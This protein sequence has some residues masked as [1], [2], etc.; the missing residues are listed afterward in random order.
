MKVKKTKAKK[1]KTSVIIVIA[2]MFTQII[3]MS[4]L[5]IVA[6]KQ[7][8]SNVQKSAVLNV[9]TALS[10][11]AVILENYIEDAENYLNAYSQSG[12]IHDMLK[13]Q[14]NK[15][16]MDKAQAYTVR[17]GMDR[18]NLEGIYASNWDTQMLVHTNDAVR[19]KVTR[20]DEGP[21]KELHEAMLAAD[22][23]YN[24]GFIISP[25]SQQQI[26]SMYKAVVDENN[27]PIGLVGC[28]IYTTGIKQL[29]NELPTYGIESTKCYL[30]NNNSKQ[31]IFHED[32][33]MLGVEVAD[34]AILDLLSLAESSTD[35]EL[36]QTKD[37]FVLGKHMSD[38]GWTFILTAD[39]DEVLAISNKASSVLGIMTI[40]SGIFLAV[41]TVI[42]VIYLLYPIGFINRKLVSLAEGNLT[43]DGILDKYLNRNNDLSAIAKAAK[44]LENTLRG[45]VGSVEHCSSNLK[46]NSDSL[47]Q[48]SRNL[49]DYVTE[50]TNTIK[51]LHASAEN[52][53]AA[54]NEI[55]SAVDTI[56]TAIDETLSS[57]E[58]SYSSGN[59]VINSAEAMKADSYAAIEINRQKL[60]ETKEDI[61]KAV[62]SLS[63]L[64]KIN[65][66]V[67]VILEITE[68]TNLL[69]LNASIEAARA[70]EAGK[71]FAVVATEI[72]HLAENSQA[73]V[74]NIQQLCEEANASIEMVDTC[75]NEVVN[76]IEE[77]V[78][79]SL[80]SLSGKSVEYTSAA[81]TILSGIS[82]VKSST[83]NLSSSVELISENLKNV[84]A[85][86]EE[87]TQIVRSITEKN[88]STYEIAGV[89]SGQ[90]VENKELSKQLEDAI[91]NFSL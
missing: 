78:F 83:D 91:R 41:V 12:E 66:M 20:P 53:T 10:D 5:Y 33:T 35:I 17:F 15:A 32:E 85:A 30:V 61:D 88:D 65:E 87:N 71:G 31:Y 63:A 80:E 82:A 4:A 76:F 72:K 2:V 40:L 51:D 1:T 58:A 52:V 60:N 70:G 28:G 37:L 29:L 8:V 22:G 24:T 27:E 75:L 6:D 46:S 48:N 11:R 77:D 14:N 25:A 59:I 50:N 13:N 69:A 34:A 23:V 21:R 43:D 16:M 18:E 86:T 62:K 89:T 38:H 45:M 7:L 39:A 56:R 67:N 90:A 19:G 9:Q 3:A 49:L 57:V 55:S 54:T 36:I 42:V 79:S 81:E 64:S 84:I 74:S 44:E 68:Q 73:T 26:I 47:E